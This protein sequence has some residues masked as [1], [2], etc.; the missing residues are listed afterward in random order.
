MRI[1][2]HTGTVVLGSIGDDLR[3][4]YTAMGDTTTVA[5]RLQQVAEPGSVLISAATHH[6]VAGLFETLDRGELTVKG[7]AP[8]RAWQVLHPRLRRSRFEASVERGLTPLVG[9]EEELDL[10]I[11]RWRRA[12]GGEKAHEGKN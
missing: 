12:T 9:R 1:G 10:L 3:M 11:R 7:H 6:L 2:L 8:V 5:A 4:D